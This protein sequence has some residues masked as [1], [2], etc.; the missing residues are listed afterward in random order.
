MNTIDIVIHC[1]FVISES[2]TMTLSK[3]KVNAHCIEFLA[4]A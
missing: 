4:Y 2:N 1:K 3:S